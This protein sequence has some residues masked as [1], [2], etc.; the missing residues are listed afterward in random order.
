[1]RPL[2]TAL[3]L[4]L[5]ASW[6]MAQAPAPVATP[7]SP[8][9][10]KLQLPNN[11]ISDVLEFYEALTKKRLIRDATLTGPN[12]SIEAPDFVTREEAI[13]MIE[14][15]LLLNG[16]SIV[17]VDENTVKI[18]GNTKQPRS[19]SVP[20]FSGPASSLPNSDQ[21]ISYFMPL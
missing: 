11:P 17:P 18:L 7:S 21:V 20:L 9:D 6:A 10:T 4:L 19:E 2:L 13:S 5:L 12:L 14:A 1:M 15:A 16:Y 3:A 8:R